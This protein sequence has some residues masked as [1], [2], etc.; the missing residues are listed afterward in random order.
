MGLLSEH[1]CE[2]LRN[3][4]PGWRR[5]EGSTGQCIQIDLKVKDADCSEQMMAR[6]NAVCE[7]MGHNAHEMKYD[8]FMGHVTVELATPSV[9]GLSENDFIVAAK[10]NDMEKADLAPAPRKRYWA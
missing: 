6:V 2:R 5:A 1:D 7:E 10:I 9:G 8:G 3:Q 4:V